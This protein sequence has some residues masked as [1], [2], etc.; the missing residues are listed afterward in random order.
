M[1]RRAF[2]LRRALGALVS[3][4]AVVTL[5]FLYFEVAPYTGSASGSDAVPVA[6]ENPLLDRYLGWFAWLATAPDPVVGPLVEATGFTLAYLLPAAVLAVLVGTLLRVYSVARETNLL[7]RSLDAVA[8]VGLS[9]PAFVVAFLLGRFLLVEYLSLLGRLSVYSPDRSPVSVRN[10][11]A[12][13][14]PGLAMTV[15]LVAVQLHHA[16]EQLRAYASEPFVR[17]ARAKG[18]S[19]WRTGWHLFRNTAVTLLSVLVTDM[20][21]AVLVAVLAVEFA[22]RTP[23]LGEL[24]IQA[25][26]GGEL[27][28][29]LGLT[30]LFAS[31]GVVATFA[32]D[33]AFALT[34]PRVTFDE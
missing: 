5:V 1:G 30:V 32:E 23:G 19:D 16:G 3:V 12:A 33:V 27:A 15:F 8:L 34:D 18:L 31:V 6:A 7:D 21:G 28:L 2:L 10:L 9:V 24:L 14:W 17:T 20:Y 26:L 4:W 22:T 29:L 13:V 25:V 11:T